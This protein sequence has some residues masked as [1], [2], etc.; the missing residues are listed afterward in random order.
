MGQD[1][2]NLYFESFF[3]DNALLE[4]LLMYPDQ[5]NKEFLIIYNKKVPSSFELINSTLPSLVECNR[6]KGFEI[7]GILMPQDDNPENPCR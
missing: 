6:T 3:S 1:Q 7:W 2:S 4:R 5:Y